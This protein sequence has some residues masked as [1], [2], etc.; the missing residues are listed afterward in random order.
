MAKK[1]K[2]TENII[3]P[4]ASREAENYENPIPSREYI[5][6][7]MEQTG[8]PVTDPLV[9]AHLNLTTYEQTEALPRRW[10]PM[11]RDGHRVSKRRGG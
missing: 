6:E 8:E 1:S 4:F 7:Y 9:C 2:D 3:D 10:T 11:A 5:L